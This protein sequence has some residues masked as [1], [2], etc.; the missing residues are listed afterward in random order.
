[1]E[2]LLDKPALSIPCFGEGLPVFPVAGPLPA[3]L[4]SVCGLDLVFA[5]WCKAWS[6]PLCDLEVRDVS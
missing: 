5:F 3:A 2:A 1:M 6:G 4:E